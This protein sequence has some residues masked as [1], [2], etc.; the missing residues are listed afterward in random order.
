MPRTGTAEAVAWTVTACSPAAD[1][2]C[3]GWTMV[4][5][6]VTRSAGGG[7]GAGSADAGQVGVGVRGGLGGVE[8]EVAVLPVD[9]QVDGLGAGAGCFLGLAEGAL[10]G[11]ERQPAVQDQAD[12]QDQGGGHHD[13]ERGDLPAVP[14]AAETAALSS[15]RTARGGRR[16]GLVPRDSAGAS[17]LL[18]PRALPR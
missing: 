2:I 5:V 17:G 9:G 6:T 3:M 18:N 13:D 1:R 11:R 8:D 15:R 7:R 4:T 10:A 16:P 14:P 12:H